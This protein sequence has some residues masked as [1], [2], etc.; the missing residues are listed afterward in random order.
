MAT[1]GTVRRLEEEHGLPDLSGSMTH[2][3]VECDPMRVVKPQVAGLHVHKMQFTASMYLCQSGRG[4]RFI[5]RASPKRCS[6]TS[7]SCMNLVDRFVVDLTT[8]PV[9]VGT[10]A[11][12]W[13]LTE[14]SAEY[15]AGR[16]K[17]PCRYHWRASEEDSK[18]RL[19][20]LRRLSQPAPLNDDM[21]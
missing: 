11:S 9:Q 19:T 1:D 10:F 15:L 13:G 4:R 21:W 7:S 2:E 16:H 20:V 8:D 17:S 12:V 6:P 18:P 5:A 14:A 3:T